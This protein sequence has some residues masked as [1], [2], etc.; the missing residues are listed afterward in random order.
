VNTSTSSTAAISQ[1]PFA[2]SPKAMTRTG[3]VLSTLVVLF[4]VMDSVMKLL[5]MPVVLSTSAEL[6]FPGT[7]ALAHTL[8]VILLIC[9]AL[10]V[11]PRTAVLGAVLLTAFLGGTVATHLRVGNPLFTHM[12]FG[13]YLGMLLWAGLYLRDASL[14]ALFPWRR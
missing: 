7:P 10:Y 4:L 14:R 9:T 12:L 11:Y 2:S 5:A 1:T 8:G 13:V 6:G 3:H